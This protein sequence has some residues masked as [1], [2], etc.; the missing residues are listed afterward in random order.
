MMIG[1]KTLALRSQGA[2]KRIFGPLAFFAAVALAVVG[3]GSSP[4]KEPAGLVDLTIAQ[5]IVPDDMTG[6]EKKAVDLLIEEVRKRS[7]AAWK[8]SHDLPERGHPAIVVGR[9]S[10][11]EKLTASLPAGPAGESLP[12]AAESYQIRSVD[13]GP[14][15][16]VAGR[17]A[18]GVLF[19]VGR[20]LREL[21]MERGRVQLPGGFHL[22]S[23][24]RY[25]LRGHQLGYR[26]K[27]NS[28]D[29]WDLP[30]WEQYIGD[31]A[32]FG[33]NAIELLPP[34]TDDEGDS[35]HFPRPP[36]EMMVGMSKILDQYGLDVW[37]WNPASE[38]DYTDPKVMKAALDECGRIFE[39][40]P[41]LDA[42]FV[43]GGD[44]GH[45]RPKVLMA[46]LE[47]ET[48]L[49][50]RFHPKAQMWVSTQG[51]DKE[52]LDE[53]YA[54]VKEE[55]KW[56][57]GI[58]Y[59]PHIRDDLHTTRAAI[60]S[61][62]PIRHYPDITHTRECQFPVP[63]WDLAFASTE[64]REPINP[65]PTEYATI[66]RAMQ[67]ETVGFLT[68]SEGCNDDVNKIIWTA[69]G[70]DQ[71]ADVV[72]ILRQYGRYFISNRQ[73]DGFAQGLLS[74]ERNW[75]GPL[76]SNAGI[77]TTLHQFQDME[78]AASPAELLN[79]RFQ[80]ALYRAYYD[81]YIKDRA[82]YETE[83]EARAREALRDARAVGVASAITR[84]ELILD[85][86]TTDGV[87]A[88]RRA[89]VF[90]LGEALYQSI[91][92]QLSVDRYQAIGLERGA[93]LD[94]IDAPLNDRV[95]LKTQFAEIRTLNS[96]PE[97]L[98]AIE[99]ILHRTDPGPGG[100]YDDL[101]NPAR[102]PHLVKG[103]GLAKDPMLRSTRVGLGSR[104]GWLLAWCQNAESLYDA[105]LRVRYD[106]LDPS[107]QY[108]VRVVYAGSSFAPKVKLEADGIE[109]HAPLKK[110]EP[111]H[112]LEFDVPRKASTDGEIVLTWT[113][114]PGRGGNGRGC[115]VGEVWLIK[116]S[117]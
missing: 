66:F 78:R 88:D 3:R 85:R 56:L 53:F 48:E 54:I 45:T 68:Y 18:R 17:D 107:A 20:L 35:P 28:Y 96:E 7:Q 46:L 67:D 116:A 43:P 69:L 13:R 82:G 51:F 6:P 41:R 90:E 99:S 108:K 117:R 40:L 80:Q 36:L 115:Q 70:W 1:S 114:D 5:V 94:A 64:G 62:Y 25:P 113:A 21:R 14:T 61:R 37:I 97:R 8:V 24:P 110:P 38:A 47:K 93:N 49:L 112:A 79:W 15:I 58:V 102:Q 52:W 104:P 72:E 89:R 101:G 10:A 100:F 59:G 9:G 33:T 39:A 32:V 65:R 4:D 105:P 30:Q 98:K 86:A 34:K 50:H 106:H 91:R 19:G 71:D 22:A 77:E 95:W 2:Q 29:A 92:M 44:P 81:A 109:V 31:L 73:A 87:S 75:Q 63:E 83:L 26:P 55:P 111:P 60:P 11:L 42:V 27:T 76:S 57:T 23:S 103:P 84:A 16:I 12:A 74:L